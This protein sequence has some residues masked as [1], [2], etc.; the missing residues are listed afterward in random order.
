MTITITD[1]VKTQ[2]KKLASDV[3]EED[4]K[5]TLKELFDNDYLGCC[6]YLDDDDGNEIA[7]FEQ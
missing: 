1:G 2:T 5:A 3:T 7:A 6:Y 4:A